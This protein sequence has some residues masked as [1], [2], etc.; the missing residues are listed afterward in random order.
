MRHDRQAMENFDA[1]GNLIGS[2]SIHKSPFGMRQGSMR[3]A[4][5]LKEASERQSTEGSDADGAPTSQGINKSPFANRQ[6]TVWCSSAEG[7][8]GRAVGMAEKN[9]ANQMAIAEL[10]GVPLLIG[11]V[12][13]GRQS[14]AMLR[15]R[16]GAWQ[17]ISR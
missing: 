16:Y 1:D 2:Q 3:N 10:G 11:M 7:G 9:Q 8:G 6:G 15:V 4:A 17:R 5:A 12:C 13:G 14:I